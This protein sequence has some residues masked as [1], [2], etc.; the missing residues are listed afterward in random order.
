M[1]YFEKKSYKSS[2]KSGIVV[3]MV[4]LFLAVIEFI[5]PQ[6][7]S[8]LRQGD[9]W[10]SQPLTTSLWHRDDVNIDSLVQENENLKQS[11]NEIMF[12]YIELQTLKTENENLKESLN[13]IETNNLNQLTAQIIGEKKIGNTTFIIIDKGSRHGLRIGQPVIVG[14]GVVIGLIAY[15]D[16]RIAYVVPIAE[17]TTSLSARILGKEGSVHGVIEGTPGV[18]TH[19][20]LV[21]KNINLQPGDIIVTSGFDEL[22]PGNLV[23]GSAEKIENESNSFFQSTV[24]NFLVDYH[25][26]D[27]VYVI[28]SINHDL[29]QSENEN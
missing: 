10:L 19:L 17:N 12:D 25:D 4:L 1:H 16:T 14:K 6:S 15:V 2:L 13:F 22:I 11:L 20:R 29:T 24:V 21:P 8:W 23:I 27:Y 7:F 3:L 28:E 5:W 9:I 18:A 26:Y